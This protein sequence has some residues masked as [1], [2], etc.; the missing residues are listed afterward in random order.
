MV[1]GAPL[2]IRVRKD[3]TLLISRMKVHSKF[4]P[5]Y[6]YHCYLWKSQEALLFNT[7]DDPSADTIACH[8]PVTWI[9]DLKAGKLK[10]RPKLGELHFICNKWTETVIVHE[11]T[12]AILHR[13]RVLSPWY[14]QAV[15]QEGIA[16][17]YMGAVNTEEIIC[18]ESAEWFHHIHKWLWKVNA[19]GKHSGLQKGGTYGAPKKKRRR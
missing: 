8:V 1:E 9:E 13:M 11:V 16:G 15:E 7:M 19:W 5:R 12:H 4:C 14:P 10:V 6:Y 18:H 3:K 17:A 2:T